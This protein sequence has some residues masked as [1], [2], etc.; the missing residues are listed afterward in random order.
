MDAAARAVEFI[1]QQLIG[2][3]R[4]LTK[5]TVH[6]GSQQAGG[7]GALGPVLD[8]RCQSGL[9]SCVLESVDQATNIEDASRI[10][11]GLKPLVYSLLRG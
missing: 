11:L 4:G 6:T 2:G 1:T 9:H 7:F 5:A 8:E 10:E 3:A